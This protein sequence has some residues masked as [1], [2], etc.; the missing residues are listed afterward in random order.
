MSKSKWNTRALL[1]AGAAGLCLSNQALA[2]SF[3]VNPGVSDTTAKTLNG[4]D[5]G[6]IAVTGSL[7]AATP[8]TWALGNVN[9]A[10]AIV[11]NSGTISGTTRGIDTSGSGAPRSFTFNN[12]TSGSLLTAT[13]NDAW[14]INGDIGAG[15]VTVNNAGTISSGGGQAL[16]FAAITSSTATVS[17]TNGLGATIKSTAD[18]AIRPG[19]G[20]AISITNNGTIQSTA[21]SGRGVNINPGS[22]ANLTSFTLT[23]GSAVSSAAL[24]QSGD[25]TLRINGTS[26]GA[27]YNVSVE[28]FGTIRSGTGQ[29]IDFDN[30]NS[31]AGTVTI[32]NRA[33]GVIQS[34]AAD[35]VRPGN[36]SIINNYG[37]ITGLGGNDGIDF[38]TLNKGT[39][40]NFAGGS[41]TGTRHG[42]TGDL[43]QTIN[44][45]GSITGQAGAGINIDSV[46][47]TTVIV[48]NAGGVIT[49]TAITGDGDGIDVDYLVDIKN[50]GTIRAVGTFAGETNE[51]L[52]IGGG[53]VVNNAGGLITSSQRAITVNDSNLGNAFGAISIDNAGTITGQ[54]GEAVNI[55][56]IFANTLTN[57]AGGTINGSV[58]MGDGADTVNLHAGS[59]LNGALD[60][61]AGADTV[62]LAGTGTGTL[63][64]V[65]NV[66]TLKVDSG[67]WSISGMQSYSAGTTVAAG[68]TALVSGSLLGNVTNNGT[69]KVINTNATFDGNFQNNGAYISDPSTQTF[70]DL[71]TGAGGTIKAGAGDIFRVGG[72]FRN[73]STQALEWDTVLASLAFFGPVGTD[74]VF[75]LAGANQGVWGKGSGNFG[76]GALVIEG[77]NT[78][79]LA[80]GVGAD[81]GALYVSD[82]IGAIISGGLI[83]N[84]AGAAG[85]NIYYDSTQAANAYLGGLNYALAGGGLLLARGVPEPAALG[86]VL[87]GLGGLRLLRR[88]R[89]A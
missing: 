1:L 86:L 52:A 43:S 9:T 2:A 63:A 30:L 67:S 15:T 42:I 21:A 56:S 12:L 5:T 48:N 14:R 6:T 44:N 24:I 29:A 78:V 87:A 54:N 28:N 82:L 18:D 45:S 71:S 83:T 16:D 55:K 17:I 73:Q 66:E 62:H 39:V 74:H 38:Q 23:N 61:G 79:Q 76:W 11:N 46:T 7:S 25:D 85:L 22:L 70:D 69:V 53:S 88:R 49:G 19:V 37:V 77:G 81:G 13:G 26:A 57:Q 80:D 31:A 10:A 50:S 40:N 59:T 51:A 60:G 64:N 68:A 8:I 47:G 20:G 4:G 58:V 84:I 3:T 75:E 89:N 32:T 65:S 35:G 72:D 41:V 36:A 27:T 33:S 34:D